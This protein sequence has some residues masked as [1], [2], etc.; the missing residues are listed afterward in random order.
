MCRASTVC[1][2]R[3]AAPSPL[4]ASTD[5]MTMTTPDAPSEYWAGGIVLVFNST[6]RLQTISAYYIITAFYHVKLFM[7]A[8]YCS[9]NKGSMSSSPHCLWRLRHQCSFGPGRFGQTIG[10]GN[11][12]PPSSFGEQWVSAMLVKLPERLS[13]LKRLYF[14]PRR[15]GK[16]PHRGRLKASCWTKTNQLCHLQRACPS[17]SGSACF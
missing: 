10:L 3:L 1:W 6:S 2:L 8:S 14:R 15:L 16:C 5:S 7:A 4:Q 13:I 9:T 12:V 17:G 11:K